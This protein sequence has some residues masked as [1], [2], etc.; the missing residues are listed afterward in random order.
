[1]LCFSVSPFGVIIGLGS[2]TVHSIV[3]STCVLEYMWCFSWLS[4]WKDCVVSLSKT[5]YPL[6]DTGS[7]QKNL[8]RHDE[9]LIYGT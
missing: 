1:M 7:I 6:F 2:L 5:L 4:W 9:L 3:K 8:S